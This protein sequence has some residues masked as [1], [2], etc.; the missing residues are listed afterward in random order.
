MHCGWK[1]TARNS[2]F[3]VSRQNSR[4]RCSR[5]EHSKEGP[6]TP[7]RTKTRGLSAFDYGTFLSFVS[8]FE[9]RETER[10][11][12]VWHRGKRYFR[13]KKNL[14]WFVVLVMAHKNFVVP[15]VNL[16]W[17]TSLCTVSF[18]GGTP[19]NTVSHLPQASGM[20]CP[21]EREWRGK[22][23]AGPNCP[24]TKIEGATGM[25]V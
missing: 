5:G 11:K 13:S 23:C 6:C 18:N 4:G 25:A 19:R 22:I 1:D 10:V 15:L 2:H 3:S 17:W 16:W 9:A 12:K 20:Y 14:F 24:T 21:I 7:A 8:A